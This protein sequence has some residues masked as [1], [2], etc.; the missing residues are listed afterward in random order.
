MGGKTS[1]NAVKDKNRNSIANGQIPP[2]MNNYEDTSLVLNNKAART[3]VAL[4]KYEARQADD[5]AFVKKD[6]IEILDD[7]TGDWYYAKNVRTKETGFVPSNY[8]TEESNAIATQEWWFSGDRRDADKELMMKGNVIGTFLFRSSTDKKCHVALSVRDFNSTTSEVTIRHYKIQKDQHNEVF[9]SANKKFASLFEMVA[10]Y[11]RNSDGL[12]TKLTKA[13]PK[14]PVVIPFRE[15]EVNRNEIELTTELGQGQFGKVWKG[16]WNRKVEVAV[17]TMKKGTMSM[18]DFI[19]EAKTMHTLRHHR[20]VQLMGVCTL[21]EPILIITELMANGS[22]IDY[23]RNDEGRTLKFSNF[24]EMATDVSEGMVFLEKKEV[25]HRDVRA[26]NILIGANLSC[27]VA[28]FGLARLTSDEGIYDSNQN[29]KFPLKWTAPEAIKTKVFSTKTDVWSFGILL[30]EVFTYGQM[31]Y[32]TMDNFTANN[33]VE[34]GYRLPRP[35]HCGHDR[36]SECP[37]P[38]YDIML[39]CWNRLPEKRP[40]FDYL[41]NFFSNYSVETEHQYLE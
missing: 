35:T 18:E 36:N 4:Y 22:L 31:P 17:K 20:L 33:E 1:K 8:L 28:D 37:P 30:F 16:K 6:R 24:I 10:H 12:C 32:P 9:I 7:S 38:V 26:A 11:T 19:N 29:T 5:L 13:C 40:S 27:K 14:E 21:S 34:K 25:V 23:L 3:M 39:K 41:F 2:R 15:L